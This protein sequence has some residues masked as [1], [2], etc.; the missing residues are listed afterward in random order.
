MHLRTVNS[1]D[2]IL[3]KEVR[4]RALAD[5]PYAFGG[6]E[7][8]VEES[9]QPDSY[10]EQ[11]AAEL[12]GEVEAWRDRCVAYFAMEDGKVCG[13]AGCY[14]CRHVSGRA[15]FS[16]AWVDRRY[17]RQGAGRMLV[18]A[19]RDWA[20]AHGSNQLRLWVDDTNPQAVEFYKSLDFHPTGESRP[21][22]ENSAVF[23]RGFET[24]L[25]GNGPRTES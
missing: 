19:A 12:G 3:L 2:A 11:L 16:G 24:R 7:T 8:L 15:Y 14:L 9:G 17:R 21:V 13:I 6:D 5:A 1:R 10:W 23:E 18:N 22:S 25:T 20:L 4:L